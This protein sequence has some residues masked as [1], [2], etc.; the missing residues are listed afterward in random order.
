MITHNQQAA[1]AMPRQV[2]LLDGQIRA[3]ST[4]VTT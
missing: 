4:V 3:D 2:E 1:A